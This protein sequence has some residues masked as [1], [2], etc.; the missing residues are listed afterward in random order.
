MDDQS[1]R[2]P[3]YVYY[4]QEGL[5]IPDYLTGILLLGA[6]LKQATTPEL[7]IL[8]LITGVSIMISFAFMLGFTLV[9]NYV[10]GRRFKDIDM[11]ASLRS[12]E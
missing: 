5:T 11:V 7:E 9:V 1:I 2:N 12:V 6:I 8:P 4:A 3:E 10:M